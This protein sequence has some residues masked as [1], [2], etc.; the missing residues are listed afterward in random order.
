MGAMIRPATLAAVG[1]SILGGFATGR[2][3]E[4]ETVLLAILGCLVGLTMGFHA[5]PQT[6]GKLLWPC[7]ACLAVGGAVGMLIARMPVEQSLAS[8]VRSVVLNPVILAG[9]AVGARLSWTC[10]CW[11]AR[12]QPDAPSAASHPAPQ[13]A[14]T[15]AA[16]SR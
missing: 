3:S 6:R 10:L 13:P 7:V 16:G 4:L 14:R 8:A 12:L 2:V 1:L 11:A 5:P 15:T 9:F